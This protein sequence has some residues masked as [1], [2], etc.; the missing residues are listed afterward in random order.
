M[1]ARR[2]LGRQSVSFSGTLHITTFSVVKYCHITAHKPEKSM[3]YYYHHCHHYLLLLF[4]AFFSP[5]GI[6][7]KD[8]FCK[9]IQPLKVKMIIIIIV[10]VNIGG[11]GIH[12]HPLDISGNCQRSQTTVSAFTALSEKTRHFSLFTHTC[13]PKVHACMSEL[14][15]ACICYK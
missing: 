13:I 7:K 11:G 3:F 10:V 5:C 6:Q 14:R 9:S 12:R 2:S 1:S 15:L 4:P 8:T